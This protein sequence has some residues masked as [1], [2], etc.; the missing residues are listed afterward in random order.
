MNKKAKL[1]AK[2]ALLLEQMEAITDRAL[3]DKRTAEQSQADAGELEALRAQLKIV[4]AGIENAIA[5]ERAAA[6]EAGETAT[7]G[8]PTER[9]NPAGGG[10]H[11]SNVRDRAAEK[12]FESLGEQLQ[13]VIR[14][15]KPG[16]SVDKRLL[17]VNELQ[18]RA[19]TGASE[20]IDQEGGF[21]VQKDQGDLLIK[22]TF[23]QGQILSRVSKLGISAK[24][25]SIELPRIIENSR[26]DG[27]RNGGVR[28]YTS[29]EAEEFTLS[30]LNKFGKMEVKLDK[31]T[32]LTAVT[33]EL[34]ED[35]PA[36]GGWL[37]MMYLAEMTHKLEH[38]I[39]YGN[40]GR[41][42]IG[43]MNSP[44]KIAQAKKTGQGAATYI[45]ENAS[46]MR[47]RVFSKNRANMAVFINQDVE[48]ALAN[49]A[50]VIG[51]GGV[52]V[53][54]PAGGA[55]V[56]GFDRLFGKP[57]I[58]T[59]HCKTLG[60]EGDVLFADLSEY[61]LV[62]KGGIKEQTSLHVYFDKDERAI[63]WTYRVGGQPLWDAP[64]T[65]KN[66]NNTTSPFVVLA[67]RA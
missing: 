65:P 22:K 28:V 44:A 37:S 9:A 20:L 40:G 64:L 57:V 10:A 59:E 33:E 21:L 19:A 53:Y 15:S 1:Q 4:D 63:K 7:P 35:A 66:G 29:A 31:L 34:A 60:E 27:E 39:F 17:H 45:W 16:A 25:N 61:L 23:E 11:I 54:L 36:L 18:S 47:M 13:T 6:G 49:M 41:E 32:A 30:K 24:S 43:I 42:F 46:K 58:P 14:S 8:E 50:M 3:E 51:T 48:D 38:L 26:A 5:E 62:D 67:V 2:R 12:P 55:S 56:D 52:P